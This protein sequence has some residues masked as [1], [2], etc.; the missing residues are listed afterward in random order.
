MN[1]L[2]RINCRRGEF[3]CIKNIAKIY[4]LAGK[5]CPWNYCFELQ[6]TSRSFILFGRTCE[7]RDLWVNGFHRLMGIPVRDSKFE[8][9]E[10][11]LQRKIASL[12]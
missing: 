12:D 11:M 4:R 9:V 8:P 1:L 10:G 3:I 7:E 5:E 2:T 6:T